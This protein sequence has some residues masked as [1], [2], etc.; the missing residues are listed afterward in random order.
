MLFDP[1]VQWGSVADWVSGLGSLAASIVALYLANDAK[2][3]RLRGFCGL[4]TLFIRGEDREMSVLTISATNASMRPTVIVNIGMSFGP[5]WRRQHSTM[6]FTQSS[7]SH[8]IP[9]SLGDGETGTWTADVRNQEFNLDELASECKL[10]SFDVE[11]WRFYIHTS[12]GGSTVFRPERALR[13]ALRKVVDER[14]RA[15]RQKLS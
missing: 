6:L 8:G 13:E 15:G 12:N 11:T 2:K 10:N 7:V 9:K 5:P 14:N 3:I 4:R 1:E